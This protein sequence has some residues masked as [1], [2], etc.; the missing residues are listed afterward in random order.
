MES[1]SPEPVYKFKASPKSPHRNIELADLFP[2]QTGSFLT[3]TFDRK[4]KIFFR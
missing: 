4:D 2:E 1:P 3:Q